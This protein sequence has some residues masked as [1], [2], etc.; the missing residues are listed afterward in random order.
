MERKQID[1][2]QLKNLLLKNIFVMPSERLS[3]G[4]DIGSHSVKVA[5]LRHDATGKQLIALGY[6]QIDRRKKSSL[7]QQEEGSEPQE[8]S[9]EP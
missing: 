2:E 9:R 6:A 8:N 4:I 1:M 5:L 3:A 7:K